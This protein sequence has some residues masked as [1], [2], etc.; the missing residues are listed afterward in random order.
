MSLPE[1][2]LWDCLRGRRLE[3]LRFRRQHPMGPYIL[4]F[5]CP[6]ARLAVEIDGG[7]HDFHDRVQ[8]DL[9]RDA[10]LQGR[11]VSVLRFTAEDILKDDRLDGALK[12]IA[13]ASTS[14]SSAKRGRGTAEGGGGG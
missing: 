12:M 1:V 10:W 6:R 3:G 14:S 8:H 2:V 7:A 13:E 9:R 11:G 4:D 5:F